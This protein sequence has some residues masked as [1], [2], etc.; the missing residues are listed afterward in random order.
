MRG[1]G[2]AST[3]G[4]PGRSTRWTWRNTRLTSSTSPSAAVDSARSTD[5]LVAKPRSPRSLWWNSMRTS[6][7]SA[8]CRPR[9]PSRPTGRPPSPGPP[10]GP[11]RRRSGL[12]ELDHTAARDVTAEAQLGLGGNA[13]GVRDR[14]GVGTAPVSCRAGRGGGCRPARR[15]RPGPGRS[16]AWRRD[17][18]ARHAAECR[19]RRVTTGRHRP[20][21]G[22]P[23]ADQR[24]PQGPARP[25]SGVRRP[26]RAGPGG[27][28]SGSHHD[29]CPI[30]EEALVL[31]TYVFGPRLPPFGRC[32]TGEVRPVRPAARPADGLPRRGVPRVLVAPPAAHRA[33]RRATLS[34]SRRRARAGSG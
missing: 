10:A 31:V 21:P 22:P 4:C 13:G 14:G 18:P 34:V 23:G 29:E 12:P 32:I 8:A 19:Q 26:S 16:L 24:V 1:W 30:C 3:K 6:A 9:P 28:P 15:R 33:P 5:P 25:P 20:P 17:L 7:A 2:T 11:A 27:T